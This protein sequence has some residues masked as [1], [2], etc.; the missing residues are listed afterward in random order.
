MNL[1]ILLFVSFFALCLLGVPVGASLG[2]SALITGLRCGITPLSRKADSLSKKEIAEMGKRI[3]AWSFRVRGTMS[4]N[5]AQVTAGGIATDEVNGKTFESRLCPGLY[6]VGE[7]LDI[8]GDCGGYNL[9]WAWSSG[10]IAGQNA[11][12]E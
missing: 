5:N 3:K 8:D 12:A 11:G 10:Y 1:I 4:W 6:I 2:L 9:Q 7:I